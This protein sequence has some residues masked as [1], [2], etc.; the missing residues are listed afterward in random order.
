[1]DRQEIATSLE[2]LMVEL[3]YAVCDLMFAKEKSEGGAGRKAMQRACARIAAARHAL[4]VARE[5][6][7]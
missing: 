1:M 2:L 4:D 6:I 5:L 7:S 3:E